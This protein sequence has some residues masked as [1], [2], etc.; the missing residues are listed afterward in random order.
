MFKSVISMLPIVN[1]QPVKVVNL[2]A[3]DNEWTYL[4]N[5]ENNCDLIK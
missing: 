3:H 2:T 5:S 4:Y 1:R